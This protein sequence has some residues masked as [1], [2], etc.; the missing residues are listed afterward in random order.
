MTPAQ[1]EP[2]QRSSPS[3]SPDEMELLMFAGPITSASFQLGAWGGSNSCSSSSNPTTKTPE[4]CSNNRP[5]TWYHTSDDD[6]SAADDDDAD[7]DDD[8]H[9]QCCYGSSFESRSD[10]VYGK[11]KDQVLSEE[12][13]FDFSLGQQLTITTTP[14]TDNNEGRVRFS[15]DIRVR[16]YQKSDPKDW[17]HLYYSA[18]ELQRMMDSYVPEDDASRPIC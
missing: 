5:T 9:S 8:D 12:I 13:R 11:K 2:Q 7:A 17:V 6:D 10:H 4:P 16:H 18:H 14:S 3:T 15:C 1:C